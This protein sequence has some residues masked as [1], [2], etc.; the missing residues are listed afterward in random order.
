M[1]LIEKPKDQY[2]KRKNSG[3]VLSKCKECYTAHR[4]EIYWN[5]RDLQLV[6]LA[7]SRA[8]PENVKQRKNYY[9]INKEKYHQRYLEYVSSGNK[10]I[11]FDIYRKKYAK[12][13]KAKAK[14]YNRVRMLN[15]MKYV[16]RKR[17]TNRVRRVINAISNGAKKHRTTMELLGCDID[18]FKKYFE[19]KFTDGMC[20]ERISEIHCDH[21]KPCCLFDLTKKEEQE[22]CF[23]YTN[24]QP[25]WAIDNMK[26]G[27]KY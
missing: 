17:L 3:G 10:K 11:T 4:K 15:D 24:L 14:E 9:K 1:C 7:K 25:L 5:N 26:K 13:L 8:K 27:G 2:T 19:E 23:H 18:F 20:W 6:K 22:K 16:L 21:I 12:E